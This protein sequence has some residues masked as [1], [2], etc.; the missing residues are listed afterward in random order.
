MRKDYVTQHS[1]PASSYLD[2]RETGIAN[3]AL[4]AEVCNVVLTLR[5]LLGSL[6]ETPVHEVYKKKQNKRHG[7]Q[8]QQ[9]GNII[10]NKC[11]TSMSIIS[12]RP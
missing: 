7:G 9:I 4:L 8:Q 10:K 5:K 3:V 12:Q 11:E 2:A 6:R 1:L